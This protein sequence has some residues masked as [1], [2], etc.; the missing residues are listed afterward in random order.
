MLVAHLAALDQAL[1]YEASGS[2][3]QFGL[4]AVEESRNKRLSRNNSQVVLD[5]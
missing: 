3:N 5:Q 2:I 4:A 1:R